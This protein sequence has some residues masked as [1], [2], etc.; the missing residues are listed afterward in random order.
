[1]PSSLKQ[2]FFFLNICPLLILIL[3]IDCQNC[4]GSNG[5]TSKYHLHRIGNVDEI[6]IVKKKIKINK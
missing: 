5:Q 1:M 4:I 2:H 3:Y 6:G